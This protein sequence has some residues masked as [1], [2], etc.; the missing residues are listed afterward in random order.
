[1]DKTNPTIPE[2]GVVETP[3]VS[4]PPAEEPTE[5]TTPAPVADDEDTI[6]LVKVDG[7]SKLAVRSKPKKPTAGKPDNMVAA[8]ERGEIGRIDGKETGEFVKVV[9]NNGVKGYAMKKYLVEI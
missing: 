5:V 8:V 1:M 6:I 3:V 4:D 9:F 7:C 2:D